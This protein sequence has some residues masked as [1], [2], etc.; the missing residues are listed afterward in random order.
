ML[1][2][3]IMG[4]VHA[5]V[6]VQPAVAPQ[7]PAAPP[8]PPPQVLFGELFA[9]V[10]TAHLYPDDKTFADADPQGEPSEIVAE[11]RTQ[12]PQSAAAL[13][14]FVAAH[15]ILPQPPPT[16]AAAPEQVPMAL[17]MEQLWDVLT[18]TTDHVPA[19][20][21]LLALPRPYVVPGGRFREMYYW[22]SY[23]TML[24]LVQ[25]HREDLVADMVADFAHQI[26]AYGHIPNGARTYYL[27]RS[28]PPFFFA[29]VE[30]L[31]GRDSSAAFARYLPE[32]KAEY[33]FWMRGAAGLQPGGARE[34]VVALADGSLLNRY[35][36]ERDSPRD[37]AYGQDTELARA[38]GREP[39]QMYRDIRAAA[40]SGWDFSSRW[41]ADAR[42]R[43]SI[44]TT[45]IVPVDLN[46]LLFGLENAI[47]AGCERTGEAGCARDFA[48]RAELRRRAIDRY[49]WDAAGGMYFDYRWTERIRIR[50][51]SAATLYPLFVALA[52]PAEARAVARVTTRLLLKD[53]GLLTTPLQTGE[54]WD[55]PNGWAPL[56][57]IGIAGLRRYHQTAL[58]EVIACRWMH[59]VR[60]IYD[61]RGKLIEKYDVVTIGRG[62][63]G[64][65]YPLQDGFGWTN[66][67]MQQL[68]ALYPGRA[69]RG[70][71]PA[72][73]RLGAA[74]P[75]QQANF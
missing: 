49:L 38:S 73:A 71:C 63:G 58:A 62:G 13:A 32:L 6:G 25:S 55:A 12:R 33:A 26:D 31:G 46:A 43:A 42:S 69:S 65:E 1:L 10:Q 27:S 29:M 23:F 47:R 70:T 48:R 9:A 28:Q 75:G 8:P 5:E 54:Q 7:A 4:A 51:P 72:P 68:M 16:V 17:H 52:S 11:Y 20:S 66:G 59:G 41:F 22:D 18:R 40:E 60:E 39:H 64:G 50:R 15:F 35:W 56:Q 36:D 3:V 30:L 53:G 61:R 34:H 24:G 74:N 2:V 44:E 45:A 67:V 21:S 14:R 57:W 37:E 19:N